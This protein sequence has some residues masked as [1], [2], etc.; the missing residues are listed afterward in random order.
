MFKK[1]SAICK[2]YYKINQIHYLG[3]TILE[4]IVFYLFLIYSTKCSQRLV[5]NM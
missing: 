2:K 5:A 4:N 3:V 1:S